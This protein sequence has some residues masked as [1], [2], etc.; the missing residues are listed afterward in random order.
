M[1][2]AAMFGAALWGVTVEGEGSRVI[3]SALG[4]NGLVGD[5]VLAFPG[6]GRDRPQSH[7]GQWGGV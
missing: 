2:E 6:P 4:S 1:M 7:E 3:V 5:S